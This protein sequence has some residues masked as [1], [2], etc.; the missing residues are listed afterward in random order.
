[1]SPLPFSARFTPANTNNVAM[2][3]VHIET[4]CKLQRHRSHRVFMV[5]RNQPKTAAAAKP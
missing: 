3:V 4:D 2:G 1:M 5:V